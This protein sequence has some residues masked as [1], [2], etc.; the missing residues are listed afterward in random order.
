[1]INS[2]LAFIIPD[3]KN[4]AYRPR[5]I[6]RE[7]QQ[8]LQLAKAVCVQGPKA[9]GKTWS[10]KNQAESAIMLGDPA[11]NFANRRIV[12][13]DNSAALKGKSPHLIDEWQEIPSLWDAVRFAVDESPEMGRFILTGSSTPLKKGVMHSGAGRIALVNMKPMSL[14]ES[15]ESSGKVSLS[16]L[17]REGISEAVS[18][19]SVRI[20]D[21][22][23]YIVRG[24]WP[25]ALD[26]PREYAS[27]YA[28]DY[29][30][31]ILQEDIP[32]VAE[33]IDM[34]K[35]HRFMRSLARNESTT[36][37]KRTLQRDMNGE[38]SDVTI[39]SYSSI[40]SRLFLV[41]NQLPF[42]PAVRSSLRLKQMEK[43]HF[44]DP[45]ISAAL[46]GM[47]EASLLSDLQTF[48]FLFEALTER[49]LSIY[50][51]AYGCRRMH[52]QDYRN[53]E[54]D[55]IVEAPDGSWGAVEIKLGAGEIDHAAHT[56]LKADKA[57]REASGKGA[58]FLAVICG[59]TT[60]AYKREDGV[61]VIPLTALGV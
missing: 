17:F 36:A 11:D 45:S 30:K 59:L 14:L 2:E 41:S 56:L 1:M 22:A 20:D 53:N 31:G 6:D 16:S 10:A 61:N 32:R 18:T 51:E 42:S 40:L 8:K 52:Y 43:R 58:S 35:M 57:M 38:I 27:S 21:L 60:Y 12:M 34:I 9:S 49:D 39:D 33:T 3:M 44:V 29:V 5:I 37:S 54:I 15:G 46:L 25:A 48:G 24:G 28:S 47:T 50:A 7:I 13:M 19:G 23:Y 4:S 55:A 26:I